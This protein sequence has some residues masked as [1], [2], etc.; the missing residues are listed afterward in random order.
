VSELNTISPELVKRK[1]VGEGPIKAIKCIV[2]DGGLL[3]VHNAFDEVYV[4]A[5]I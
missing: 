2:P 4:L 3:I 5:G 1:T